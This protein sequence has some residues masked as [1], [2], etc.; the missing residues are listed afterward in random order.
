MKHQLNEAKCEIDKKSNLSKNVSVATVLCVYIHNTIHYILMQL[1]EELKGLRI[2]NSRQTK[3]FKETK[4]K[5]C[6]YKY[7]AR[8]S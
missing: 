7:I 5:V 4:L 6:A 3:E 2:Q 1:S 8:Y